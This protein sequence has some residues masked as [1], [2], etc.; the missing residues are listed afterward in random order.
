MSAAT[1]YQPEIKQMWGK[2]IPKQEF[3]TL[4]LPSGVEVGVVPGL[5]ATWDIDEGND[6]F[7]KGA[8]LDSI[9]EH[10]DRDMRQVR[11]SHEHF[12]LIGGAPIEG[13]HET[14]AGLE[15]EAH[16][17][18]EHSEGKDVWALIRQGVLVD[19]SIGFSAIDWEIKDDIRIISKALIW[20][21]STVGEPMNRAAQ[22]QAVKSLQAKLPI[23][24][25]STEWNREEA[26]KRLRATGN[27][28]LGCIGRILVCDL[29]EGEV[30]VIP[31]ALD[32]LVKS[33]VHAPEEI[34]LVERYF[35]AMKK[36]SPFDR[37]ER[38]FFTKTDAE[39][40]TAKELE[41][42]LVSTDRV[43]RKTAKYLVSRVEGLDTRGDVHNPPSTMVAK[44][45]NDLRAARG[46]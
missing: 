16:V 20:H 21:G 14:S 37:S 17:N 19:F 45:L 5:L 27:V 15:I 18:L 38:Q 35:A 39:S 24:P 44:M 42:L 23:A 10:K 13:V 33:G 22:I 12:G 7:H 41:D 1:E 25:E 4:M 30:T 8:F 46:A 9:Q 26:W 32:E 43:S 28:M 2:F 36:S 40:L 11:I 29:V 34:R 6:R 31:Q 3:K